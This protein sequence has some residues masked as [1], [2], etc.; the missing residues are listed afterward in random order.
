MEKQIPWFASIIPH[1]LMTDWHLKGKAVRGLIAYSLIPQTFSLFSI[2]SWQSCL[3]AMHCDDANDAARFC[4]SLILIASSSFQVFF[5]S[6]LFSFIPPVNTISRLHRRLRL[7]VQQTTRCSVLFSFFLFRFCYCNRS[8]FTLGFFAQ[9]R[10][11]LYNVICQVFL[12]C[13][14][15]INLIQLLQL[16]LC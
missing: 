14:S 4:R 1:Q 15:L 12:D 11:H 7:H 5:L 3:S 9:I 13:Y 2:G 6:C 8:F 10:S 16:V